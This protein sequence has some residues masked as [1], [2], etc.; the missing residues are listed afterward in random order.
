MRR[1]DNKI[2]LEEEYKLD[3]FNSYF[4]TNQASN[5][6]KLLINEHGS[7]EMF[8]VSRTSKAKEDLKCTSK[9]F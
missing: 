7:M 9:T 6:S 2:N 8:S 1:K 5:T 4:L 3:I